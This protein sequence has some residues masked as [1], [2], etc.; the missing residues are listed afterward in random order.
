MFIL[1]FVN[2]SSVKIIRNKLLWRLMST[3]VLDECS[4]FLCNYQENRMFLHWLKLHDVKLLSRS[5]NK[6]KKEE[7]NNNHSCS[8]IT[9]CFWSGPPE[10]AQ[11]LDYLDWTDPGATEWPGSHRQGHVVQCDR[12]LFFAHKYL[13]TFVFKTLRSSRGLAA[14]AKK[15]LLLRSSNISFGLKKVWL[16]LLHHLSQCYTKEVTYQTS[17]NLFSTSVCVE[18]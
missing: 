13:T 1:S 12:C 17:T 10:P 7:S 15:I 18:F 9:S 16:F 3:F 11:V 6:T 5:F 8:S 4:C 14:K 2:T